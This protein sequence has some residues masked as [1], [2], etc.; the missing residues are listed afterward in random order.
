[1][2]NLIPQAALQ[3][4]ASDDLEL[5]FPLFAMKMALGFTLLGLT[6][7]QAMVHAAAGEDEQAN[8]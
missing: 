8:G 1:M 2:E 4:P 6:I 3:G 7:T 5:A